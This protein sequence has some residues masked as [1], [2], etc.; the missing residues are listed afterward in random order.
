[1]DRGQTEYDGILRS[2]SIPRLHRHRAY[3]A[4][5]SNVEKDVRTLS[6]HT[7]LAPGGAYR[8]VLDDNAIVRFR[9][10]RFG[11]RVRVVM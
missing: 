1:M 9:S 3:T 7:E 6:D 11:V 8:S 4:R 5:L 2:P 10:S